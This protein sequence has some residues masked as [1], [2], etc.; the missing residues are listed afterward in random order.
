MVIRWLPPST[1][2]QFIAGINPEAQLIV[3]VRIDLV[4]LDPRLMTV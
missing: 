1:H 4:T 2:T 3:G